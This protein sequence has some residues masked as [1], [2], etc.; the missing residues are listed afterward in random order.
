LGDPFTKISLH[1]NI[2]EVVEKNNYNYRRRC[3]IVSQVGLTN[4]V[5]IY[6]YIAI[7]YNSTRVYG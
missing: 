6:I 4:Y 2:E 5:Y 1:Q 3:P 7:I